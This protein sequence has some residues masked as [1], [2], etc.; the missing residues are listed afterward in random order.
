MTTGQS[1]GAA[2][3][4][5]LLSFAALVRLLLYGLDLTLPPV[6]VI[7]AK[8]ERDADAQIFY[9]RGDGF[10]PD[11]AVWDLLPGGRGWQTLQFPLGHRDPV[12]LRFDPMTREGVMEIRSIRLRGQGGRPLTTFDLR[13]VPGEPGHQ[14]LALRMEEGVLRVETSADAHDPILQ[15]G[16]LP[17]W[18]RPAFPLATL[19]FGLVSLGGAFWAWRRCGWRLGAAGWLR[20]SGALAR[21]DRPRGRNLLVGALLIAVLELLWLYPLHLTLDLP[22][23]DEA[24]AMGLG[25]EFL[26]SGQLGTPSNF[27]LMTLL[28]AGA[29]PLFG[30]VDAIFAMHY[31]VKTLVV[32]AVFLFGAR[33]IRSVLAAF[34][35]ALIWMLAGYPLLA[36]IL[37]YQLAAGCF[38]LGLFVLPRSPLNAL[39][40]LV[41]ATLSRQ[42]YQFALIPLA[43]Y[44]AWCAWRERSWRC[45][46]TSWRV[47]L[48]PVLVLLVAF[49]CFSRFAEVGSGVNR[50]W[51]AFQQ[52]YALRL[53][54]EGRFSGANPFIDYP[55]VTTRDFPDAGSLG[56]AWSANAGAMSRHVSANLR[57][58]GLVFVEALVPFRGSGFC[59]RFLGIWMAVLVLPGLWW[60]VRHPAG[61]ARVNWRRIGV[62]HRLVAGILLAFPV[63][64]PGLVV[65]SKPA[66]LL[67]LLAPALGLI[68]VLHRNGRRPWKRLGALAALLLALLAWGVAPAPFAAESRPRPV[69][70][71]V[72]MLDRVLEEDR[73][74]RVL[75]LTA[76]GYADYLGHD[77]IE[78]I[79]PFGTTLGSVSSMEGLTFEALIARHDP[80]WIVVETNWLRSPYYDETG[81]EALGVKG[82]RR[83]RLPDGWLLRR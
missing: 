29:I 5:T 41:L 43:F 70:E 11:Q 22:L 4:L 10:R 42:E 37:V 58:A 27:P 8:S 78:P 62:E 63:L 12:R 14:E 2:W 19:L 33:V 39:A 6:V 53:S 67:P 83:W 44:L 3:L 66:Y 81:F 57:E 9:D 18:T 72:A 75:G 65:Y 50:G 48:F 32:V 69:A 80:D 17:E 16:A 15:L 54:T 28:Y 40:F 64:A 71:T 60:W 79:D 26:R 73:R 1:R 24:R 49:F 59:L 31:A 52:H 74:Q 77:R 20:F 36:E 30:P 38:L 55:L 23:W 7:E 45:W 76:L 68:A 82:W 21:I 47:A 25:R 56:E 61:S 34:S 46:L 35:A 51:Y 13:Q